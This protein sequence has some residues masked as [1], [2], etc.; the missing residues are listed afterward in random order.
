MQAVH[1]VQEPLGELGTHTGG[2]HLPRTLTAFHP[3]KA[4][5][6]L[7][8]PGVFCSSLKCTGSCWEEFPCF[9]RCYPK[10]APQSGGGTR[11]LAFT[12]G[13]RCKNRTRQEMHGCYQI[14]KPLPQH[15][16]TGGSSSN[17]EKRRAQIAM[18]GKTKLSAKQEH[19]ANRGSVEVC[20]MQP[21]PLGPVSARGW[22]SQSLE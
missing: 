6:A 5:A 8:K 9:E 1:G 13:W 18:G 19:R 12:R 10:L 2:R 7:Q 16:E 17:K 21:Q 22:A 3:S 15:P 4:G 11:H 14:T 20:G